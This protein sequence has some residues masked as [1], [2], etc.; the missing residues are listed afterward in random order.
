MSVGCVGSPFNNTAYNVANAHDRGQ[1]HCPPEKRKGDVT[2]LVT[3][4][5]LHTHDWAVCYGTP[6][7]RSDLCSKLIDSGVRKTQQVTSGVCSRSPRIKSMSAAVVH[8]CGKHAVLGNVEHWILHIVH[9]QFLPTSDCDRGA[10]ARD[11]LRTGRGCGHPHGQCRLHIICA[12][13]GSEVLH[14]VVVGSVFETATSVS[15]WSFGTGID[16]SRTQ[17]THARP[18]EV[19][20]PVSKKVCPARL[21]CGA[22]LHE[23]V[24]PERRS[25]EAQ[26]PSSGAGDRSRSTFFSHF[27]FSVFLH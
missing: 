10:S 11:V 2:P 20:E 14:V 26:T 6:C 27:F 12:I 5:G 3:P 17:C 7:G 18:D 21:V 16:L 19:F 24:T 22:E 15:G 23:R 25:P 9:T 1:R 13:R 8:T 4:N